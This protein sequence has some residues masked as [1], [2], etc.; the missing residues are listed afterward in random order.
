MNDLHSLSSVALNGERSTVPW[1][2][3]KRVFFKKNQD[4]LE[5]RLGR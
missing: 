3:R 2:I 4:I 1:T 5:A